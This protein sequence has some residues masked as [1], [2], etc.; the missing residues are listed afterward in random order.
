MLIAIGTILIFSPFANSV[1]MTSSI[2]MGETLIDVIRPKAEGPDG[3]HARVLNEC[4]K[5]IAL[6][7]AII[8]S[9]SLTETRIP[10]DWKRANVIPIFKKGDKSNVENY[11]PV[12]LTS[13]VCKTMESILKD[14]IVDFLDENDIIRDTQHGFRRGRSCLTNLL[15]FFDR[16]TESFDKG[17]QLDVS[18]LDFSKAF[19]KVPHKRL[20]LQLKWHGINTRIL[21]WIENWL[22]GRQQRVLLNG[23]KSGWNDVLS[24]VPARIC[25][26]TFA[27]FDIH[28]FN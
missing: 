1:R 14:K 15:E 16:A 9:R 13:L 20:C 6:P 17:R 21:H 27:I 23:T 2:G 24:G 22:S 10:L 19:D 18:Y 4:E 28:K 5:E 26:R 11:R 8:F 25:P 12:S 3:I 7:L